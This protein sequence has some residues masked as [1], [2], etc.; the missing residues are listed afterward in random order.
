MHVLVEKLQLVP[1]EAQSSLVEQGIVGSGGRTQIP[2]E[3]LQLPLAQS[4]LLEHPPPNG[5]VP[6]MGDVGVV[7]VTV[8][9]V[10]LPPPIALLIIW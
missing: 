5:T 4:A 1:R 8:V 3:T 6:V 2:A 9:V 10:A 7:G